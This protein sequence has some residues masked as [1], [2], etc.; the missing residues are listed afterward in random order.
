ML[1][2][3]LLEWDLAA[4]TPVDYVDQLLRRLSDV[5]SDAEQRAAV[6]RHTHTF[7][8]MCTAGQ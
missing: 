6:R 7:I 8:A 4:V 5:M 1:V 3:Q 2:V